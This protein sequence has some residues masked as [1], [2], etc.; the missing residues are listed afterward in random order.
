MNSLR[1]LALIVCTMLLA[2]TPS[3]VFAERN[4]PFVISEAKGN[5][6]TVSN[7]YYTVRLDFSKG[8]TVQS[9]VVILPNG[10]R[11]ELLRDGHLIPSIILNA[12]VDKPT[13]RYEF[14]FN[15]SK[16]SIPLSTLASKPWSYRVTANTTELL[17]IEARPSEEALVD[18]KPLHVEATLKFRIWSPSVEYTIVF[19]NP[20]NETITLTGPYGGPEVLVVVNDGAPGNWILALADTGL[21]YLGGTSDVKPGEPIKTVSLEAAALVRLA[22]VTAKTSMLYLAG[23]K[24]LQPLSYT[25]LYQVGVR[26]DNVTIPDPVVMR[27]IMQPVTLKPGEVFQLR[28]T[29]AYIYREPAV[30][31]QSGLE[32]AAI[33]VDSGVLSQL[34]GLANVEELIRNVTKPLNDRI[35]ELEGNISKLESRIRELEGLK[36]FWDNEISIRDREIGRLKSQISR[37]NIIALGLLA[38]GLVLGFGGGLL[39]SRVRREEM[40]AVRRRARR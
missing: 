34:I 26:A 29:V 27:L 7:Y 9:W 12:Y 21:G 5:L 6:V 32:P 25:V 19:S 38:L 24:P 4:P 8:L 17:V 35:K 13:G 3:M 22:N 18:V 33:I 31:A 16:V 36:S 11:V 30:I 15:G 2:V 28:F 40:I 23:F 1:I 14:E 37:A 10:S 20:S 39:A